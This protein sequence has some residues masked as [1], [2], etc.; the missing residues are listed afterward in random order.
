[1]MYLRNFLRRISSRSLI[2]PMEINLAEAQ[3]GHQVV[4][5]LFD[6]VRKIHQKENDSEDGYHDRPSHILFSSQS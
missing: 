6:W 2:T 5:G 4:D 3:A 1:M